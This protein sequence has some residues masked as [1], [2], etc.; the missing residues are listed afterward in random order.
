MTVLYFDARA[1]R[2]TAEE[3]TLAATQSQ[4]QAEA[5]RA[6]EVKQ[7]KLTQQPPDNCRPH[8]P[9]RISPAVSHTS[10]KMSRGKD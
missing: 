8:F 9:A 7:R 10:T 1:D 4:I 3:K 6:A 5:A 2:K